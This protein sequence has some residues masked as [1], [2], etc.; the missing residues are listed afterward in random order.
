MKGSPFFPSSLETGGASQDAG[1]LTLRQF[2][3]VHE[4]MYMIGSV[5]ECEWHGKF[6]GMRHV[7]VS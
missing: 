7:A 1:G 6:P 2:S 4:N 3:G 5:L